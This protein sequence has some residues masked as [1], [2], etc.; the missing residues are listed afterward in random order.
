[1]TVTRDEA[2]EVALCYGWID[3]Q[4][5]AR[6]PGGFWRQRFGPRRA[7]SVWSQVNCAKAEALAAAGRMT[8]AG[9]R[10]IDR[11]KADGRWARAYAPQRTM[12]VPD[13]LA[14]AL[15]DDPAASA[16]FGSLDSRNRYAILYRLH[17]AKRPE[18]RQRRLESFLT[19]LR[20]G[21]K[22]H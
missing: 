20:D 12:E 10:E 16:F 22:L 5:G 8:P 14:R 13:D 18:T 7:R 6:E 15:A 3:S 2:L 11:A 9:Q 21:R 17:E 1:T 19:M 4:A